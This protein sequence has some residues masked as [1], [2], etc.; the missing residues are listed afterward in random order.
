[1]IGYMPPTMIRDHFIKAIE[2]FE[3]YVLDPSL[4]K[5]IAIRI[6]DLENYS[7]DLEQELSD[8]GIARVLAQAKIEDD[9]EY[10]VLKSMKKVQ[11]LA[12]VKA[13]DLEGIPE[14]LKTHILN[15]KKH[16]L[17]FLNEFTNQYKELNM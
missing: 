3:K 6:N 8:K 14:I 5:M 4:E 10:L 9:Q 16:A 17:R 1:M 2:V 13:S 15:L 12:S 7:C 11:K